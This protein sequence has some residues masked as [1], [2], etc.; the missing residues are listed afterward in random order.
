MGKLTNKQVENAKPGRHSDGDG[1]NLLVS[2]KGAKSWVLRVQVDGKRKDIGLGSLAAYGL[3]EAR[4]RAR[5]LRKTAKQRR[6]PIAERDRDSNAPPSFKDAA[7]ACH[8]AKAPGWSDKTAAAFLSS[9]S[10]HVH[11]KIG[12]LRV[13]SITERDV[14][15]ALSPVWHSK[16]ALAKKLRHRIGLILD[17]SKASGWRNEGAP[18]QSLSALLS[19]QQEGGNFSSMPYE[20]LPAFIAKLEAKTETIGRLAL[21][22]TI[23][24]AARN[25]EVRDA[26]WS[27]IDLEAGEWR[28]PASMMRK[29][30]EAHTITLS[31]EAVVI[32]ERAKRW[33]TIEADCHVFPGKGGKRLSDM[34]IGKEMAALPYVV[35]G[36]R[37]TFRTWAAER[38]P[39]IPEAVAEAAL[40]HKIPDKV[41]RAYN[42]AKFLEMRRTLLD[43]WGRYAAGTSGDVVQLPLSLRSLG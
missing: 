3:A 8:D 24:T 41:V 6:D 4:D 19:K 1:L 25:G 28:R 35:H 16:P 21:L 37:S 20:E 23:L 30:G 32:L 22:F 7:Q 13:D 42:R 34:T 40:A 12:K 36:F 9:L 33:R 17:Y 5:E 27:Q 14:A 18:R 26:M 15:A 43:A 38:M 31:P 39:S 11:P 10:A 2:S 29:N